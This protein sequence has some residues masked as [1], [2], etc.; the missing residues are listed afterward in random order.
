MVIEIEG[1][2]E[3]V[4]SVRDMA[5]ALSFYEG[6]LGL[7]RVSPPEM[8]GPVFLR[9]GRATDK[10]PAMVVLAPLPP[11]S[12]PFLAP[13]SLHHLA[14]AVSEETFEVTRARLEDA[15]LEVRDGKHPILQARTIYVFD[16]DGNEVELMTP[17]IPS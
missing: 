10:L 7:E 6:L 2:T 13:R 11:E 15:G 17:D 3:V 5:R 16:P 1:L 8:P 4:L 12:G 9:A 14:L